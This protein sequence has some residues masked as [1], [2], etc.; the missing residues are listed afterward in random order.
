[1]K[2]S[3]LKHRVTL[4]KRVVKELPSGDLIQK[5]KETKTIWAQVIPLSLKKVQENEG[6]G[7][8]SSAPRYKVTF[9]NCQ[10]SFQRLQWKEDIFSVIV[11][12]QADEEQR[13][14]T[15]IVQ[16]KEKER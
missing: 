16:K 15:C 11:P 1:M 2:I 14:I 10:Q 3:D 8:E 4:L 7:E 12:P 6:W 5:W 13:W 9:R